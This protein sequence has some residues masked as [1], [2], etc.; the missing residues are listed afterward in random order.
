MSLLNQFE[1]QYSTLTAEV[2]AKIGRLSVLSQKERRDGIQTV[3]KLLTEVDDLLDQ[4]ELSVREIPSGP[5]KSKYDLRVKS[6]RNDKSHLEKELKNAVSRLQTQGSNREELFAR[7]ATG[8]ELMS[9]DQSVQLLSNTET[10]ERSTR[11]LQESYQIC[12]ETEQIGNEVL[13]NLETQRDTINRARDRLRET[14]EDIGQ[15]SKVLSAMI[16]RVIQNRALLMI[17]LA[18]LLIFV[19]LTIYFSF[20]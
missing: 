4:M 12:V 11:K 3:E 1:Q 6:Y 10:L 19:G 16:R 15:S 17:V 14:E 8:G 20:R 5:D 2:T 13:G 18:F 7:G 9:E